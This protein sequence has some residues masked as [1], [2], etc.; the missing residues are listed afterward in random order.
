VIKGFAI[1]TTTSSPILQ[2]IGVKRM[3]VILPV[4]YE[5]NWLKTSLLLSEVLRYLV[6]F[7][8]EK[9]NAYPVSDLVDLGGFN[10]PSLLRPIGEKLQK[11]EVITQIIKSSHY[12]KTKPTSNEPWFK[13]TGQGL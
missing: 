6:Q 5:T 7:P 3:P 2:S 11:E 10:D 4:Q 1:I 13:G 12:H 9:M 8:S